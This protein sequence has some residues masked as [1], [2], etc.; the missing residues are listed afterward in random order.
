MAAQTQ[1]KT[2]SDISVA[3]VCSRQI[4][5]CHRDESVSKAAETMAHAQV[6]RLPVVDAD[7]Q[8]VGIIALSDLVR[9]AWSASSGRV[10]ADTSSRMH[11][12]LEAVSRPRSGQSDNVPALT[13]DERESLAMFDTP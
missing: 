3:N 8:L 12:L 4:Y 1:G 9:N 10:D 11:T 6:R 2:L 7:G 13:K 5:T